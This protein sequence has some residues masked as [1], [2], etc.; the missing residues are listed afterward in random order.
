MIGFGT[1]TGRY[2]CQNRSS[3]LIKSDTLFALINDTM[4][5]EQARHNM[6]E[7]QIR[8]WDVLDQ[9]VLQTLVDVRREAFV[10]AAYQSSDMPQVRRLHGVHRPEFAA[11][12]DPARP[13]CGSA[14]R[15]CC[16]GLVRVS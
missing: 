9:S 3:C 2:Q 11:R 8:T 6:I 10:P 13:R 14:A 1:G 16:D 15:S 12:F 7:Q 5:L 4:K